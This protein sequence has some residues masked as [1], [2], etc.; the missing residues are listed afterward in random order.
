MAPQVSYCVFFVKLQA[1]K[2]ENF[3]FSATSSKKLLAA[4]YLVGFFVCLFLFDWMVVVCFFLTEF[5]C[6]SKYS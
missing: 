4:L 3:V 5:E 1:F 2:N 6:L